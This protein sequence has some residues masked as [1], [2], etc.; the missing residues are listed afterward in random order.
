MVLTESTN[1]PLGSAAPDFALPD[2]RDDQC[3]SLDDYKNQPLLVVF[4]CN[5]CPYVVHLIDALVNFRIAMMNRNQWRSPMELCA[6]RIFF[7]ST[8][9]TRST[10][11]GNLTKLA[12]AT[13]RR[14]DSTSSMPPHL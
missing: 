8:R 4:M 5:H 14:T 6:H 3:V 7:C 9:L 10:I 11:M 1:L 13:G 2:T 12:L